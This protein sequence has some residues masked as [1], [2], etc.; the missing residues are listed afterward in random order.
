MKKNRCCLFT[1]AVILHFA[2][3]I[4][5]CRAATITENFA[6][7]PAADGWKIFG[8][9]SLIQWDSTNQNLAVTWDSSQPNSY[10]YHPLGT[11]LGRNDDFSASFDLQI[12]D[13]EAG[14]NPNKPDAIEVAL[15]F[16]N[17]AQATN[18][19]VRASPAFPPGPPD[20]QNMVEFDYFPYFVDP[21]FGPSNPSIAPTFISSDYAFDGAFGYYF[22]FTNGVSY[23]VQSAYTSS[24]QSFTTIVT[25]TGQTN[26]LFT[27]VATLSDTNDF[28]VDTFSVSCYSDIG[29]DYDSVFGHGTV[30]NLVITIPSP[31]VVNMT[32]GFTNN[33][34]QAQ[35]TSRTNW[36]YTLVR[37]ADFQ[38]W[39][40][41]SA[42]VPGNGAMLQLQDTNAPASNAFYR[43]AAQMP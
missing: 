12:N 27:V 10:F 3:C 42:S 26:I 6:T 15:G 19:I 35:F 1:L 7:D 16:F 20:P 38:S 8:D 30:D 4:F 28:R 23:N 34:W 29:D 25:L 21:D 39:S 14:V 13:I 2:F 22:T 18:N 24:N 43:V 36:L 31:P 33:T 40:P 5:D 32:G 17:F 11:I 37:T 9:V 41:A